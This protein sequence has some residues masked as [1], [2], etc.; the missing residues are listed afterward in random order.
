MTGIDG[1]IRICKDCR[2]EFILTN[3]N[4]EFFESNNLRLPQRCYTCRVK[5]RET[6]KVDI[7]TLVGKYITRTRKAWCGDRSFIGD[8]IKLLRVDSDGSMFYS[9]PGEHVFYLNGEI[10]KLEPEWNDGAWKEWKEK[11]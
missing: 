9:Y 5:R 1:E 11:E 2:E 7:N 6:N 8:K 3:R 10:S 4:I